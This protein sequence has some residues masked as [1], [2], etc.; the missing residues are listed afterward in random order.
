M[1]APRAKTSRPRQS[2]FIEHHAEEPVNTGVSE[3]RSPVK[4]EVQPEVV[5]DGDFAGMTYDEVLSLT[6][7]G[8]N[9]A[10]GEMT[11]V[12][13]GCALDTAVGEYLDLVRQVQG[14]FDAKASALRF[15]ATLLPYAELDVSNDPG[16]MR[17]KDLKKRLG[18]G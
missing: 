8:I 16:Q 5:P 13:A 9:D 7:G 17:L 12:G 18:R 6:V 3:V 4:L 15:C 1:S 14:D 10:I 11:I 2:A